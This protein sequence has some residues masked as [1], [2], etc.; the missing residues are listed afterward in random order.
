MESAFHTFLGPQVIP[1]GCKSMNDK[2][3]F[4]IKS[5]SFVCWL[6]LL[7]GV[8][9][10]ESWKPS[11]RFA[12]LDTSELVPGIQYNPIVGPLVVNA[13]TGF[14]SDPEIGVANFCGEFWIQP[15]VEYSTDRD[16][17][18]SNGL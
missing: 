1:H 17:T 16:A 11:A 6:F 4:K 10:Y 2:I 14:D 18:S 3:C 7:L 9:T 12:P 5:N 15:V 13:D 8:E